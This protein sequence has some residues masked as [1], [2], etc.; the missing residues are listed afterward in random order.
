MLEAKFKKPYKNFTLNEIYKVYKIVLEEIEV[1]D[2]I[3]KKIESM[4]NDIT[5]DA[6][7]IEEFEEEYENREKQESFIAWLLLAN[8]NGCL[9]LIDSSFV[10]CIER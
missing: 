5:Q 1:D 3:D 6:I 4:E 7:D 2:E 9:E 8:D 10:K